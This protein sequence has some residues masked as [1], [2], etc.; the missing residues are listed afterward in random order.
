MIFLR[1]ESTV[2]YA[3]LMMQLSCIVNNIMQ[4][5][6]RCSFFLAR[7]NLFFTASGNKF[8]ILMF[9]KSLV[10]GKICNQSSASPVNRVVKTGGE[11]CLSE[12]NPI[13]RLE[14]LFVL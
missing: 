9:V 3:Y 1:L 5:K 13:L 11:K 2:L 12:V 10:D 4:C 7:S 8:I 6:Y 14:Y